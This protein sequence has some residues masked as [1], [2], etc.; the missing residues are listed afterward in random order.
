MSKEIEVDNNSIEKKFRQ[1]E[2]PYQT[3]R[4]QPEDFWNNFCANL[5]DL[6]ST[7][8]AREIFFDSYKIDQEILSL[9]QKLKERQTTILLSNNYED[10]FAHIKDKLQLE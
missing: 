10:L 6:I 1:F 5:D 3:G 9:I 7:D 4:I 2:L 8:K